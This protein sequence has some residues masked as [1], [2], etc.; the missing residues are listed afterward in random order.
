MSSVQAIDA[1]IPSQKDGWLLKDPRGT[2]HQMLVPLKRRS[3]LH[4]NGQQQN[5]ILKRALKDAYC[6]LDPVLFHPL[7]SWQG[8]EEAWHVAVR[9]NGGIL[10]TE[11]ANEIR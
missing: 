3:E 8:W 1:S 6:F 11:G 2:W 7:V 9:G 10:I 4:S 5:C